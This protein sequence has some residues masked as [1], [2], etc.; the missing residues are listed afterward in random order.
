MDQKNNIALKDNKGK[1]PAFS[2]IV[3]FCMFMIIGA[4]FIPLLNIQLNPSTALPQ[5]TVTYYWN[6]ASARVIEQ[7]VTTPLEGVLNQ[8]K[9]VKNI[10]SVSNRGNGTI[11]IEFD[12]NIN[13]DMVRFEISTL[14]RQVYPNLPHGVSYPSISMRNTDN[15]QKGAVLTYTINAGTTPILIEEYA[16]KHLVPKISTI[17]GVTDVIVYGGTPFEWLVE[18]NIE[19]TAILG[20]SSAEVGAAISNHFGERVVG[21]INQGNGKNM[22]E[23]PINVLIELRGDNASEWDAVPVKK[24]GGRIV[25]LNDI[26]KVSYREQPPNNYHRINGLNS[27]NMVIYPEEQANN[28]KLAQRVKEQVETLKKG[29]P[30]G[31]QVKLAYDATGFI[32]KELTKIGWRTLFS[33]IILLLFVLVATRK[34]RYLLLILV[35]IV[36]NLLIA[37]WFYHIFKVEIHLYA[38]AGITVSFGMMIDNSIVMIDHLRLRGNKKV[39]LAILAATLTTI[40]AL[41]VIFFLKESQRINLVD[42]SL[43]IIINLSISI[44]IAFWFIPALMEKIPLPRKKGKKSF[45]R[46]RHILKANRFYEKSI[47][48]GK[49]YKWIYIVIF[50][51][52]FG[53]PV[54]WLPDKI[55]KENFWAETYNKT[56]GTDWFTQQAKPLLSKI[57]GGSLRLFTENVFEKSFYSEPSRTTLYV[58]GSMPEGCTVKQLNEAVKKMEAEI[59]VYPEVEIFQTTIWN[60]Q[61]SSIQIH[62]TDSAEFTGFPYFLKEELTS[63]AIQLGGV[64]WGVY[65][66]GRG[67][68]NALGTGYKRVQVQFEGYNY[69]QLYQYAL[70]SCGELTKNERVKEIEVTGSTNWSGESLHEYYLDFNPAMFAMNN[71]SLRD[72]YGYLQNKLYRNNN[73][74]V[75]TENRLQPVT[76]VSSG[77]DRFQVWNLN[78]E[79]VLLNEKQLK[80]PSIGSIE[81]RKTGNS[82]YKKNQQYQLGVAYNFLG[83]YQLDKIVRD[84][85]IE[86]VKKTLPIGYRVLE[87]KNSWSWDRNNKSQYYLIFLVIAII[88]FICAILL[89]SLTQPLAVIGLV[90]LSFIGVFLTFYLFD[91]NFDQGGF[92]SFI[93]LCGIS[94]N[95][96]LYILNDYNLMVKNKKRPKLKCYINAF[97]HKIFPVILT[98]FSTSLGLIPFVWNGQNEVF[99]F[100]FASGAIGGLVFSL[101]ALIVF[102]PLMMKLGKTIKNHY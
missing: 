4:C 47:R 56:L 31:Y 9:G 67:F 85:E 64:D 20:I 53:I 72:F 100:S 62:F 13:P 36:A 96:G 74:R 86:R 79:P 82:I 14:I 3:V 101:L 8:V 60:A 91:I 15:D 19:Q 39:F 16:E 24:T 21:I 25:Y 1:F 80:L 81:K 92:A 7:E 46:K 75:F 78:N 68:S 61:S 65:G 40:G 49:K 57:L 93:L 51:L 83:P 42:F 37:A 70:E 52:G 6:N 33:I 66:V 95:S 10:S 69:D 30:P 58:R 55:E 84:R 63:K 11:T 34:W 18:L 59:S 28:L 50:L 48:F 73:L 27:I 2:I 22:K 5:T 89:E 97:N 12:K 23:K 71:I 26:A 38:L 45:R 98:I 43:V 99:W 76:L 17:K 87:P 41:S 54:H 90:P 32:K 102:L 94:V 88:Y 29:L 44:A 35:S 77:F